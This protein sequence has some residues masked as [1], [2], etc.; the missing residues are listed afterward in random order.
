MLSDAF[1]LAGKY[2]GD[3]EAIW[4]TIVEVKP[5]SQDVNLRNPQVF[6]MQDFRDLLLFDPYFTLQMGHFIR[7]EAAEKNQFS[8]SMNTGEDFDYYLRIWERYRCIKIPEPFFI[9]R[10]GLHSTGPKSATGMEWSRAV[11]IIIDQYR[12]KHGIL[13]D[14]QMVLE[15]MRTNLRE[16][17]DY[18]E[19]KKISRH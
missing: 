15:K 9:N 1:E 7:T 14:Q 17:A 18:L 11:E 16:Y 10:R 2:T 6:M 5:G 19:A 4:G 8:E 13:A 3:Y 12:K